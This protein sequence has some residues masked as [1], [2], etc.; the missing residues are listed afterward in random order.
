M[1]HL[2]DLLVSVFLSTLGSFLLTGLGRRR[3]IRSPAVF[4]ELLLFPESSS[5]ER[6][7][8]E[9]RGN[10]IAIVSRVLAILILSGILISGRHWPIA[11]PRGTEYVVGGVGFL[12]FGVAW[13]FVPDWLANRSIR[14]ALRTELIRIG[15]PVCLRCGYDLRGQAEPR[16]PECGTP[17]DPKLLSVQRGGGTESP[18][19]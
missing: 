11:L 9:A 16:C 19:P 8:S 2:L 12:L 1:T 17:F 3:D 15:V 13:L 6:A 14:S 4:P 5:A 18:R 7:L 10:V